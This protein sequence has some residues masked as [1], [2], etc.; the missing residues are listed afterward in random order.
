L[1][2]NLR[3]RRQTSKIL[4]GR[5]QVG[6]G[7]HQEARVLDGGEF[8]RARFE[9]FQV[10]AGSVAREI[11]AKRLAPEQSGVLNPDPPTSS[12]ISSALH[13]YGVYVR[14]CINSVSWIVIYISDNVPAHVD[15]I[16]IADKF[17]GALQR[18]SLR[19]TINS[20][21]LQ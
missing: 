18:R 21:K 14:I 5:I 9:R 7:A 19:N 1:I 3:H 2:K 12:D 11:Y 17:P 8:S 15:R 10:D 16:L 6:P 13:V 4:Q 20:P